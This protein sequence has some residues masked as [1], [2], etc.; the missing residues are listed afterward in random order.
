[1]WYWVDVV[2]KLI[3]TCKPNYYAKKKNA[4]FY[5]T[6]EA[7]V[8]KCMVCINNTEWSL[9]WKESELLEYADTKKRK[10]I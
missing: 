6:S 10:T 3:C 5:K 2:L 7:C 4:P 8:E 1:M 9:S